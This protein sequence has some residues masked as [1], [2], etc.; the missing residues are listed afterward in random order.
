MGAHAIG[1]VAKSVA[2]KLV[3]R[4]E[5]VTGGVRH[6]WVLKQVAGTPPAAVVGSLDDVAG[7][8]VSSARSGQIMGLFR[9]AG[10]VHIT[11]LKAVQN[12]FA[13]VPAT[14]PLGGLTLKFESLAPV[15]DALIGIAAVRDAS[16]KLGP[17]FRA[18]VP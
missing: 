7:T 12:G 3:M 1:A 10:G 2:A 17:A 5:E 8:V 11:P 6:M 14:P 15:N 16:G 13:A 9:G 18:L 4:A